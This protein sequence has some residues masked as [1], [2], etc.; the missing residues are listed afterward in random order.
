MRPLPKISDAEWQVMKVIWAESPATANDVIKKLDGVMPWNDKTIKT[1]LGRLVKK[2]AI[3]YQ[4]EGRTHVY[5]PLVSEEEC[6]K[7]E[8]RSFLKRVYDGALSVMFVNFLEQHKLSP[9]EIEELKEIL[10]KKQQ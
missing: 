1:L 9:K 6:I 5:F 3:S 4:K 2:G 7:E 10:D 8:N